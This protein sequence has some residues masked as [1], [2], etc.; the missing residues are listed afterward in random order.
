MHARVT[1][2]DYTC[3]HAS[4]PGRKGR[5]GLAACNPSK[6]YIYIYRERVR[7]DCQSICDA[8]RCMRAVP[9][10]S[11]DYHNL[12]ADTETVHAYIFIFIYMQYSTLIKT[13][14]SLE[15]WM[16]RIQLYWHACVQAWIEY[17]QL[18][19]LFILNWKAESQWGGIRCSIKIKWKGS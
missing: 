2:G 11:V 14:L 6:L 4:G 8:M 12:M 13:K 15:I 5:H 19:I 16:D 1:R 17:M 7:Y 10:S 9:A 18:Y 3:M